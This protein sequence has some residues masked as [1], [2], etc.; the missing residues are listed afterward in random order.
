VK[1]GSNSPPAGGSVEKVTPAKAPVARDQFMSSATVEPHPKGGHLV[2]GPGLPDA[3]L[4]TPSTGT[5]VA[6][7]A[8]AY[9]KVRAG[10]AK[11]IGLLAP[12]GIAA[13]MM[14]AANQAKAEGTSQVKAAAKAG[15]EGAGVMAGFMGAQAGVT[16]GLMKAGMRAATAIP[17]A[18]AVMMAGG[19]LHGAMTAKPGERLAG[20]ARGAWDMSLPGMVANTAVAAHEAVK[21]RVAVSQPPAPVSSTVSAPQNGFAAANQ[22]FKAMQQAKQ[23]DGPVLRGTQN[24]NNLAA[25]V[26]NRKAKAVANAVTR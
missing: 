12:V 11:A 20:A 22:A 25:I 4:H 14:M 19:A 21:G 23:G 6:A 15:A 3:G 17:G 1:A 10:T 8:V 5:G 24:P 16:Y 2:K 13:G 26:E 7:K 9:S 18:N